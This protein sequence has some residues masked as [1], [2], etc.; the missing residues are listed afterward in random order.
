MHVAHA[1]HLLMNLWDV[2]LIC[3]KSVVHAICAIHTVIVGL[4]KTQKTQKTQ[5]EMN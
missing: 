2:Q 5:R 1:W 4:I 3:A